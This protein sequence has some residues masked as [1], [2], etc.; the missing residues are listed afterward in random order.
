MVNVVNLIKKTLTG[1]Y[2][3]LMSDNKIIKDTY[4]HVFNSY[5]DQ[6]ANH[7]QQWYNFS[8][9]YKFIDR[10]SNEDRLVLIIIG[11]QPELW[12]NVLGRIKKYRHTEDIC[13]ISPGKFS[14]EL[15]H[16]AKKYDWSYLSTEENKLSVAQNI[17]IREHEEAKY[18][19]KLDEDIFI[20]DGYFDGLNE[21]LSKA[22]QEGIYDV[23]FVAPI[24]NVNGT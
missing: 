4:W 5:T 3:N 21:T 1:I 13:L 11:Y 7:Y 20:G 17:A 9:N 23:G 24:L 22:E 12:G 8:S 16:I 2:S 19:Y 15:N 14:D 6:L 18:I 10:S